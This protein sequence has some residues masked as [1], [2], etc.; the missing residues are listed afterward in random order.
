MLPHAN[1]Q[2]ALA[3]GN[4]TVITGPLATT[5]FIFSLRCNVS[6]ACTITLSKYEDS[7]TSTVQLYAIDLDAEDTIIDTAG[8]T[9]KENDYLVVNI[10]AG[11]G[12]FIIQMMQV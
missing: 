12:T 3:T 7:S 10:S 5:S 11:T 6:N 1:I 9:V 8:Y 2:G 4:N